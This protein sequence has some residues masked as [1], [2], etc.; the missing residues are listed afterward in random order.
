VDLAVCTTDRA[1]HHGTD[2]QHDG[3]GGAGSGVPPPPPTPT[4]TWCTMAGYGGNAAVGS[5][6]ADTDGDGTPGPCAQAPGDIYGPHGWCNTDEGGW[7][8]CSS[9]CGPAAPPGPPPSYSCTTSELGEVTS[10]FCPATRGG[11][12][13]VPDTCPAECQAK[14]VPWY[15]QCASN[16]QFIGLDR[17]FGG[18][19]TAFRT[20]CESGSATGSGH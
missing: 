11:V 16:T 13:I 18:A 12:S 3:T 5:L 9:R 20:L 14:M 4:G 15:A 7:G 1:C 10:N 19:L 17:A 6:C 8:A 2:M